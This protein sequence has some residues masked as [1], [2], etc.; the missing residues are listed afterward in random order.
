VLSDV[1]DG[2]V[3]AE[4]GHHQHGGGQQD[5]GKYSHTGATRGLSDSLRF[6]RFPDYG[7]DPGEKRVPAQGESD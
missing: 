3:I 2:E 6:G 5:C 7:N 1:L 4:G